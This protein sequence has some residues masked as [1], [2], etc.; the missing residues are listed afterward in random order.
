MGNKEEVELAVYDLTLLNEAL[1][2]VGALGW[3]VDEGLSGTGLGLLEE[4]LTDTFVYNDQGDLRT[5][6]HRGIDAVLT[7]DAV[8]L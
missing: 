5:F 6:H 8:L 2:D 3:V 1:I 4:S 7:E